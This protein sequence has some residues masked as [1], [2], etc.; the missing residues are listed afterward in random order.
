MTFCW[1]A[2]ITV[3]CTFCS[4]FMQKFATALSANIQSKIVSLNLS[5][6]T[7]EDRGEWADR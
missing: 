5:G 1:L 6:N 2:V 4:D 3:Y 7:I